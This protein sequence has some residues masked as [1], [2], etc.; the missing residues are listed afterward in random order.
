MSV[1]PNFSPLNGLKAKESLRASK[2]LH[3][4]S[5]LHYKRPSYLKKPVKYDELSVRVHI[6]KVTAFE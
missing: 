2:P 3:Y 6:P 4:T 1:K 5:N